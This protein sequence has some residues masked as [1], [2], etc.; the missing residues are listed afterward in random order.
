MCIISLCTWWH[1]IIVYYE[2]PYILSRI[3]VAVDESLLKSVSRLDITA[4]CCSQKSLSCMFELTVRWDIRENG[5]VLWTM[6][7]ECVWQ[8]ALIVSGLNKSVGSCV[9]FRYWP[10]YWLC[11]QRLLWSSSDHKGAGLVFLSAP[12]MPVIQSFCGVYSVSLTLLLNKIHIQHIY[13]ALLLQ[14]S[15]LKN[16][17]YTQLFGEHPAV[18]SIRIFCIVS[19]VRLEVFRVVKCSVVLW[20]TALC[21]VAGWYHCCR[22]KYCL[23]LEGKREVFV[24]FFSFIYEC[25]ALH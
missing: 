1:V 8:M 9:Q 23:Y 15:K 20:V 7:R 2:A 19:C 5:L 16:H 3:T 14:L 25:W 18:F 13:H 24:T 17:Q 11:C 4:T 12:Y 6:L 10:G 21:S 22:W